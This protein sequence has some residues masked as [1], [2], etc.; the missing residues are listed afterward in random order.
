MGSPQGEDEPPA[1]APPMIPSW[2]LVAKRPLA[3]ARDSPASSA[4]KAHVTGSKIVRSKA[5]A[6]HKRIA[7]QGEGLTVSAT[8]TNPPPRRRAST[9]Q[10]NRCARPA[11]YPPS[12][13]AQTQHLHHQPPSNPSKVSIG[14]YDK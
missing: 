9:T 2:L 3:V 12:R 7:I 10:V 11:T 8:L 13:L 6:Q 4:V 5:L 14:I 1:D